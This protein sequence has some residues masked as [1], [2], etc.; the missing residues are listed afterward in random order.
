MIALAGP[1][2]AGKSRAADRT[3]LPC[4]PTDAF[5]LDATDSRVPLRRNVLDWEDVRSCDLDF[6]QETLRKTLAGD[7]P[8]IP[9]YSYALDAR[10]GWRPGIGVTNSI[11]LVEGTFAFEVSRAAEE[12]A[13]VVRVGLIADKV[14]CGWSRIVRD[15]R[16]NRQ[17]ATASVVDSWRHARRHGELIARVLAQAHVVATR[18]DVDQILSDLQKVWPN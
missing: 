1:S 10:V 18:R 11:L 15:L 14:V 17:G 7:A 9:E 6:A 16:K 2:G 8:P 13:E 12:D 3:G 5:Y 4:L